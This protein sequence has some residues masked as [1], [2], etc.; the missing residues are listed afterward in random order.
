[1][2]QPLPL[3]LQLQ[4]D[5]LGGS[6]LPISSLLRKSKVVAVKLQ[7]KDAL[8]WIDRE[9]NGYSD[10]TPNDLPD[11]RKIRGTPKAFN[12]YSGWMPVLIRD[13]K[14]AEVMCE[15]PL[16]QSAGALEELGREKK[17][18]LQYQYSEGQKAIFRDIFKYYDGEFTLFLERASLWA[19]VDMIRTFVLN[20]TLELEAADVLG[21]GMTFT[22]PE[23]EIGTNVTHNYFAQNIG[24]AGAVNDHAQVTNNQ[25]AASGDIDLGRLRDLLAQL[26]QVGPSLP[27]AV[28]GEVEPVIAQIE[29][30]MQATAPDKGKLR[31]LL[32]SVK[33]TCEGAAGN[34]VASGVVEMIK[35]IIGS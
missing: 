8:T 5:A 4:S 12:P 35:G 25:V 23:K 32:G 19:A 14:L 7:V 18:R 21:E 29:N 10:C 28:R 1:M 6:D 34:L 13:D 31:Q 11:Y 2:V 22:K 24:V 30:E 9:L 3:V 20:W 16:F 27:L 26:H 17:G 33:T 15:A